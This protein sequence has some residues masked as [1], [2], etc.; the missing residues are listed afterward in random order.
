MNNREL[1]KNHTVPSVGTPSIPGQ[2]SLSLYA[3]HVF[4]TARVAIGNLSHIEEH[5][6]FLHVVKQIGRIGKRLHDARAD[7]LGVAGHLQETHGSAQ[8]VLLGGP[9]K[10]LDM[11]LH[12]PVI[13]SVDMN[14]YETYRP[15]PLGVDLAI[16]LDHPM[17][18]VVVQG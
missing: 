16:V 8:D 17:R 1:A 11:R 14:A 9:R 18:V 13:S 6:I 5:A 10:P 4:I 12:N 15:P 2:D 7:R 3:E